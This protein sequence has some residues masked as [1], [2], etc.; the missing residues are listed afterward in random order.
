MSSQIE[1]EFKELLET[2]KDYNEKADLEK[3]KY[4]WEF[5]KIAHTSQMRLTGEEFINHPLQVAKILAERKLDSI[6][7]I[8]AL[9]HDTI[10]DGGA[11]RKDIVDEFGE[12]VALLVDGVTKVTELRLKGSK[13]EAYTENLRKLL[14]VMA[15]DLRVV[16]VKLADRLHNMRTLSALPANKQKENAVETLEIYAPLADRMG[17]GE[18]KG[19]LEDL[20]FQYVHPKEYKKVKK[21]ATPHYKETKKCITRM[22]RVLL[23][24]LAKEGI[25]ATIHGREKHLYSLWS[26]LNRPEIGGDFD[27][28]HDIVAVRVIVNSISECYAALG[29][30][31]GSYTP[32]PNI[33]VSDFIA[34]PKPHGYRSIHTKVFGPGGRIVEI[35]IRTN[36]M[37][38]QAEYGIAAHW[39]YGE[40][41]DSGAKDIVLETG[42]VKADKNKLRW[43]KQL[44]KWQ[45]EVVDS[46]EFIEAIK[47]DAL[48]HRNYVFSPKGDV[49][50]LPVDSTP[51]DFGFAVHSDLGKFIKGAKVDGKIVSLDYKLKSGQVVEILKAK[52]PNVN[53]DWLN[54]V[55]TTVARREIKKFVQGKTKAERTKENKD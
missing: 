16:M 52:T 47:F 48:Q 35:Q 11:T 45:K 41:K 8:A 49:Y 27:K 6:S 3:I 51:V 54:F 42:S 2:I 14:L 9:L 5:A 22:R 17:I 38:K 24:G 32:T 7:I 19:E 30:V 34:Q 50:D 46:E 31:H 28:I 4:A 39:A 13:E 53:A 33:G 18:I 21:E 44:I 43:V 26:K 20:A 15:K 55:K 12:D 10:E 23:A 25:K 36:N 37:H 1:K 40:A 29:I